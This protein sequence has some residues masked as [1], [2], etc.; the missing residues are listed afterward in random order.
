MNVNIDKCM[1]CGACVGTCPQNAIYLNDVVL[2]FN[3][4]CNR[5]GLCVKTC[6]VGALQLE[7]KA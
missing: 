4:K 2:T 7:A 1:H 6:P 3:D 5:C